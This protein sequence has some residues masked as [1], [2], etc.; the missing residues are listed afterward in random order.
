VSARAH[1]ACRSWYLRRALH[2]LLV[3]SLLSGGCVRRILLPGS[4]QQAI[5]LTYPGSAVRLDVVDPGLRVTQRRRDDDGVY[6][7]ARNTNAG[8][9]V[10]LALQS[11][12]QDQTDCRERYWERV[13]QSLAVPP[14]DVVKSE[15]DQFQIVAYTITGSSTAGDAQRNVIACAVQ[16]GVVAY[17]RLSKAGFQPADQITFDTL[18][19]SVSLSDG[20][21]DGPPQPRRFPVAG[22]GF[23]IFDVP[24]AWRTWMEP[25]PAEEPPVI[26]FAPPDGDAWAMKLTIIT[27]PSP[28]MRLDT[29]GDV[30]HLVEQNRSLGAEAGRR[31]T[32][33]VQ[34][35]AG[36]HITGSF[37]SSEL[38]ASRETGY[39][40]AAAGVARLGSLL[41]SFSIE[42]RA[43]A[44]PPVGILVPVLRSARLLDAEG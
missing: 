29:A 11:A 39:K 3:L 1:D 17:V 36:E 10:S 33:P 19:S 37:Y 2:T 23:L 16:D 40:S 32:S 34:D 31:P 41:L 4:Q 18:L 21:P 25:L 30:H 44:R 8:L 22:H 7:Y 6:V 14:A 38:P 12:P 43:S 20:K 27:R 24:P 26:A 5:R 15:Y 42:S 9:E 28:S 35:F 13:Q